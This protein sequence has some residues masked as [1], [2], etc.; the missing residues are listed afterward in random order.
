MHVDDRML[1]RMICP[2]IP[3]LLGRPHQLWR[4]VAGQEGQAVA[5]VMGGERGH[6]PAPQ[7]GCR[8]LFRR[9]GREAFQRLRGPR[10]RQKSCTQ[11]CTQRHGFR[12]RLW[13][14]WELWTQ[15]KVFN[16]NI[17]RKSSC[18]VIFWHAVLHRREPDPGNSLYWYRRVG[19]HP[20]FVPLRRDAAELHFADWT[21][22][23]F[24]S[25]CGTGDGGEVL[26]RVQLREWQLLFERC[27]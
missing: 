22:E 24:V 1:G 6:A 8:S 21:P 11:R 18:F 23:R 27:S 17:F 2:G 5:Q 19:R 4:Q 26:Q 14:S 12:A 7:V 25:A 9:V 10:L 16:T 15:R 13:G 20:L 3:E